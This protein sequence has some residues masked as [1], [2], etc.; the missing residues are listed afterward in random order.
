MIFVIDRENKKNSAT[1]YNKK[2]SDFNSVQEDVHKSNVTFNIKSE[3]L[4]RLIIIYG[5][6]T[7]K[8]AISH[9]ARDWTV[10]LR[11]ECL[12]IGTH[13]SHLIL[14]FNYLIKLII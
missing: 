13:L 9:T 8:C 10:S 4:L 14:C 5:K 7:Y 3:L 12:V 11:G 6:K 1:V 2:V